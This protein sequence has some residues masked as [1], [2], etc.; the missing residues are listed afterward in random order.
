MQKGLAYNYNT[1]ILYHTAVVERMKNVSLFHESGLEQVRFD[2]GD[3][4]TM[5]TRK[6]INTWLSKYYPNH[7]IHARIIKRVLTI[8]VTALDGVVERYEL[9][10]PI[11]IDLNQVKVS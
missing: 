4:H 9:T 10:E 2:S 11:T 8:E 7:C 3:W 6:A 1:A 5:S